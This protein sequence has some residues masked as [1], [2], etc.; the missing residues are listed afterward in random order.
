M[1]RDVFAGDGQPLLEAADLDVIARHFREHTHEHVAAVFFHGGELRV[2]RFERAALAAEHVDLPSRVEMRV[3]EIGM[4]LVDRERLR[5][6]RAL[7]VGVTGGAI[8]G[9]PEVPDGA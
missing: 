9:R 1:R 2:R 5:V 8:D 6:R 4:Q 7:R 3:V